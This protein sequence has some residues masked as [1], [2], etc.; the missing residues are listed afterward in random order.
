[1]MAICFIYQF[2][3]KVNKL[4]ILYK[5]TVNTHASGENYRRGK[6]MFSW[7]LTEQITTSHILET[8][9]L[10]GIFLDLLPD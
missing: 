6:H 4:G 9:D 8:E 3:E 2:S 1:M 5:L 7:R 10:S